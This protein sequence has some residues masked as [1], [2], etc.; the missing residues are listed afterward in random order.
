MTLR[1]IKN[2]LPEK[3]DLKGYIDGHG[4]NS[5]A[6]MMDLTWNFAI[7]AC[8]SRNVELDVERTAIVLYAA[9][10]MV[11]WSDCP[12]AHEYWMDQAHALNDNLPSLLK[13]VEK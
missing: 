9:A 8:A 2:L 3:K 6:H 13:V 11:N 12:W 5:E 10:G 1:E 7:D 4:K